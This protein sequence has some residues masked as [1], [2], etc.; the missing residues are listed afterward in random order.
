MANIN[1][2][3]KLSIIIPT[4][5]EAKTLPL[6]LADLQPYQNSCEII[7]V[8]GG[9]SDLTTLIAKLWGTKIIY[10]SKANPGR[11]L[12]PAAEVFSYI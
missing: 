5:N 11:R 9:S 4:L 10:S 12:P 3:K 2:Y 1:I 7:V 6:L 8:D